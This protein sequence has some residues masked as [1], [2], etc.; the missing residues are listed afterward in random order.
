[1]EVKEI[2][3]S[4]QCCEPFDATKRSQY[5]RDNRRK[6][7]VPKGLDP[8]FCSVSAGW[9]VEGVPYCERHGGRRVLTILSRAAKV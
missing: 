4:V 6:N 2:K 9:L 7:M 3:H 5:E 8:K 1:M